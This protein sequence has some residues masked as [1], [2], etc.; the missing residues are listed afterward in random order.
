MRSLSG[1]MQNFELYEILSLVKIPVYL[2]IFLL[3]SVKLLSQQNILL[4]G[5]VVDQSTQQALP[6]ASL[7]LK[8]AMIGTITN[9][10]GEFDLYIPEDIAHDTLIFS[11]LGYEMYKMEWSPKNEKLDI[12]LVPFVTEMEEIIVRPLSVNDY[13]QRITENISQNYATEP[14]QS[15]AFYR[16]VFK[17][18]NK[19]ISNLEGVFQSF[20]PGCRDTAANQHRLLLLRQGSDVSE[21]QFMDGWFVKQAKKQENR[22]IDN[23]KTDKDMITSEVDFGGPNT[24]LSFD[25]T[26]KQQTFLDPKQFKN[27]TYRLGETCIW[28]GRTVIKI[29]F[30]TKHKIDDTK[31]RGFFLVDSESYAIASV[32]SEGEYLIPFALQ[33]VMLLAGISIDDPAY[34]LKVKYEFINGTWYPKDFHAQITAQLEEKHLF[35][36]NEKTDIEIRQLFFINKINL[37][38]QAPIPAEKRFKEGEAMSNQVYGDSSTTWQEMNVLKKQD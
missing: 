34:T 31:H 33:P 16:E 14:F 10:N 29:Y 11:F 21:A 20:Y 2:S 26:K 12:E 13:I 36:P 32:D 1:Q 17:E 6:Y 38:N 8:E 28:Q 4:M 5:T 9:E 15:I 27:Y 37:E 19:Y 18:N 30:E 7:S 25:F 22:T 24:I 35:R 3:Y 23:Q